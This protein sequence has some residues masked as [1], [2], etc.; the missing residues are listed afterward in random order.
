[1]I[2]L[3]I[4]LPNVSQQYYPLHL[5]TL[6][7]LYGLAAISLIQ[8]FITDPGKVTTDLIEQI[9]LNLKLEIPQ[10]A[11][12]STENLEM[13][14]S[15]DSH[16]ELNRNRLL[17]FEL[18]RQIVLQSEHYQQNA[19]KDLQAFNSTH[20]T[21]T[22]NNSMVLDTQGVEAR[23]PVVSQFKYCESCDQL[24]PPRAYHCEV[25]NCC[26]LRIDHHCFWMGNCI[27]LYNFK[28]FNLYLL[29]MSNACGYVILM[30]TNF[31]TIDALELI[32]MMF[33]SLNLT[34][35]TFLSFGIYFCCVIMLL[36]NIKLLIS[37]QTGYELQLDFKV[38]PYKYKGCLANIKEMLLVESIWEMFVPL[39]PLQREYSEIIIPRNLPLAT[40]N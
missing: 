30:M 19:G 4:F 8:T 1:M 10:N 5:F 15:G 27:G 23:L 38:H 9:K 32:E 36:I 2:T 33:Y 31:F 11:D 3:I 28:N 7:I 40:T 37:N 21:N 24:Q 6:S 22:Q 25:C 14:S 16:R 13:S 17:I 39:R 12:E 29:Y 26:I 18:N 20:S 34:A 35:V